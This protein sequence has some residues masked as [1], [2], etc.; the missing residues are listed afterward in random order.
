MKRLITLCAL[1]STATVASAA[2]AEP[3]PIANE[4]YFHGKL[5]V[6][7]T[8]LNGHYDLQFQVQDDPTG[9]T[10]ISL[11]IGVFDVPVADGRFIARL[12]FP[13][14]EHFSHE[15]TGCYPYM[16]FGV[17]GMQNS[18][19]IAPMTASNFSLRHPGFRVQVVE[20]SANVRG[21]YRENVIAEA[22]VG[23]SILGGGRLTAP[24]VVA[25]SY[26]SI[27]GGVGNEVFADY[28]I[29]SGGRLNAVIGAR[30]FIGSGRNNFIEGEESAVVSGSNNLA[31]GESSFV[32]AG[33]QNHA[34]GKE[35][36]VGSGKYNTAK[37]HKSVVGGGKL[38]ESDGFKSTVPGGYKNAAKGKYS[39]A[40][41]KRAKANHKGAFV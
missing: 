10:P 19:S 38:N 8:P 21:G 25:S 3:K 22:A 24:N 13:D 29:V 37:G 31:K 17:I 41:G 1:L 23:A 11:A 30:S 14:S 2:S 36:F 7:G 16:K 20:D 27:L 5:V 6:D 32:G 12:E 33:K 39:F 18:H 26:A 4:F 40:A 35:A 15:Y 34:E 9:S 28:A